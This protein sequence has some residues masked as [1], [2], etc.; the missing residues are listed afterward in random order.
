MHDRIP[1]LNDHPAVFPIPS[2]RSVSP[3]GVIPN[4]PQSGWLQREE[5]VTP[6]SLSSRQTSRPLHPTCGN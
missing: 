6:A 5:S 1:A 2:S 4:S 3:E